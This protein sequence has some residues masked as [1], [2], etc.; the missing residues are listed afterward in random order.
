MQSIHIEI[1]VFNMANNFDK[2]KRFINSK[3]RGDLISRKDIRESVSKST[4]IDTYKR[5]LVL[6]GIL[7]DTGCGGIYLVQHNIPDEMSFNELRLR[8]YGRKNEPTVHLID[9]VF[10]VTYDREIK[11]NP[12]FSHTHSFFDYDE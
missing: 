3:K 11:P 7:A 9:G 8:A 1:E 2:L 12:L 5:V 4:T 10:T 6:N